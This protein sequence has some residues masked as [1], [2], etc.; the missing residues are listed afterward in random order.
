MGGMMG[1]RLSLRESCAKCVW[2]LIKLG[3]SPEHADLAAVRL[4]TT[5]FKPTNGKLF[6]AT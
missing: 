1:G 6:V 3:V 2:T 4:T 5:F